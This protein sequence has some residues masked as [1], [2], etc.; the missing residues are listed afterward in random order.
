MNSTLSFN[1]SFY[2]FKMNCLEKF[3]LLYRTVYVMSHDTKYTLQ[4][5]N[6][7]IMC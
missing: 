1:C 4:F 5:D 3:I 2:L 7:E 6:V